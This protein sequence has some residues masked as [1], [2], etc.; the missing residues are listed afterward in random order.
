LSGEPLDE[1]LLDVAAIVHDI[2][3]TYLPMA[4]PSPDAGMPAATRTH[5]GADTDPTGGERGVT[6]VASQVGSIGEVS[7]PE[8]R[9]RKR[10]RMLSTVGGF[11]G[12]LTGKVL[13][14]TAV[15]AASVGGL[16][17]GD[18]VDVPGLPGNDR[19]AAEQ[20]GAGN[21]DHEAASADAAAEEGQQTA[22]EKQAAAQAYT[23]AVRAWTDCVAE[24]AA[25][26]G[27]AENRAT[28]GFD[29]RE[30]C[31]DQ[32]RPE[33]YGL[34]DLPSQAADVARGSAEGTPPESV[35]PDA[36]SNAGAATPAPEDAGANDPTDRGG[37]VPA[38]GGQDGDDPT[39][40][41]S[42]VPAS[43]SNASTDAGA[44]AGGRP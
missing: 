15:A 35:V 44:S 38:T 31:G 4:S 32:P 20:S 26:Q 40:R 22:A 11:V 33:D 43:G 24:A 18:V 5:L 36:A 42:D 37:D 23:D 13:V 41:G 14:G 29:P 7:D 34:T 17:A 12:T 25:A 2:R 9:G 21:A 8:P 27:D 19:P 28:G 30:E 3:A 6:P 10:S 39:S 1:D 16:H